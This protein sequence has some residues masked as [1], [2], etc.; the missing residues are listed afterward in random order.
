MN[1]VAELKKQKAAILKMDNLTGTIARGM[2]PA[3]RAAT[4]LRAKRLARIERLLA[5]AQL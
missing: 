5:I 3:H 2:L 4:K 1:T